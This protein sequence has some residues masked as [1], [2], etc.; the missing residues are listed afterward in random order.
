MMKAMILNGAKGDG[1]DA[2]LRLLQ[3]ALENR[4]WECSVFQPSRMDLRPC[5]GC[6]QCWTRTPGRC[7]QEDDSEVILRA[8][9]RCELMALIS[10]IRWGSYSPDLKMA[11]ERSVPVLLPFFEFHQGEIHHKMRYPGRPRFLALGISSAPGGEEEAVF[12][13]L[14]GRNLLNFRSAQAAVNV[15]NETRPQDHAGQILAALEG[16]GVAS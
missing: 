14:V 15:L 5:T 6:F 7:A 13:R 2:V 11:L 4:G 16:I 8:R 9:A 3:S 1:A 10:P 12:R